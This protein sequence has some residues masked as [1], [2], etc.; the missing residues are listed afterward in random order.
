MKKL[1]FTALAIS[2]M[3][4]MSFA[5]TAPAKDAAVATKDTAVAKVALTKEQK[6]ALK[7]KSDNELK[8]AM[9]AAGFTAEQFVAGQQIMNVS[10]SK[11]NEIKKSE[12]TEEEKKAAKKIITD[13]R[14]EDLKTL[15]GDKVKLFYDLR[16]KQKEAEKAQS[17][18]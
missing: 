2:A 18:N 16:N 8:A 17:G 3:M 4:S 9:V 11:T 5:Q 12:G 13:K 6:K 15:L 7:E 10:N 14:N 1:V